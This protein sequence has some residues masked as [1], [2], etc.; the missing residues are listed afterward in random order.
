MLNLLQEINSSLKLYT[1][2]HT[3]IHTNKQ[4]TTHLSIKNNHGDIIGVHSLIEHNK[5]LFSC[6]FI[7]RVHV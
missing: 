6:V 4:I 1:A 5:S 7:A 3:H 2:R